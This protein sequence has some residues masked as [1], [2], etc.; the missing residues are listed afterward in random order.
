MTIYEI[1]N[2]MTGGELTGWA[3]VML[4]ILFSLIQISPLKLNPWDSLFGWIGRKLNGETDKQL[5]ELQNQ[6]SNMWINSHRHT[7]LRFA[8]ESRAGVEHSPDE[9]IN[10]LNVAEEYE[11]Y[12]SDNGITNGIITQ[13]TVY[14]REL[15]QELSREHKII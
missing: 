11:K 12:V 13:D 3:V 2:R 5:K 4:I 6:I 7:I 8:R 9:W 10:L 1:V 15:Y 14:L